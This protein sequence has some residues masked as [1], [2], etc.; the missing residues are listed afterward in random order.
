M[1]ESNNYIRE[2][3]DA[4]SFYENAYDNGHKLKAEYGDGE[5]AK[6]TSGI[7]ERPIVIHNY[8]RLAENVLDEIC[9]AG[10]EQIPFFI[11]RL[12][13]KGLN[14]ILDKI[15]EYWGKCAPSVGGKYEE[16]LNLLHE[17]INDMAGSLFEVVSYAEKLAKVK[18]S[19][20]DVREQRYETLKPYFKDGFFGKAYSKS[21]NQHDYWT[22]DFLPSLK[23][24]GWS[25]KEYANIAYLI[26]NSK[27]IQSKP[28]T[29]MEFYRIFCDAIGC[30]KSE[31]QAKPCKI[32]RALESSPNF[33]LRFAYLR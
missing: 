9:Q 12:K 22:F 15:V 4:I 14:N 24:G 13:D 25:S 33:I 28:N 1:R 31:S 23:L 20:F 16:E 18:K 10:K 11:E 3:F 26:Y 6:I 21:G 29:F 5:M 30:V 17:R 27:W 7:I 8:R 19:I 32:K 2:L